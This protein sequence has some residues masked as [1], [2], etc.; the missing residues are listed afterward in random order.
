MAEAIS[1]IFDFFGKE[2]MV[3]TNI[4]NKLS[5]DCDCLAHPAEPKM[6]DLG[7]FASTDSIAVD[8]ACA[9]AVDNSNDPGKK[10]LIERMEKKRCSYP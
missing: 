5:V 3:H 2:N 10:G 4:A 1:S 7:I 6:A 9:D 8:Q